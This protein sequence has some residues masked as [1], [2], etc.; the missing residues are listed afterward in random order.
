MAFISYLWT[1]CLNMCG[2]KRLLPL[3]LAVL[4][5]Y[6]LS[7]QSYSVS[8]VVTDKNSGEPVEF[9]TVVLQA[10]EQWAVADEKGRFTIAN[11]HPGKTV[12]STSC[13]GYVTDEME[14]V[15]SKSITNLNIKLA[16][17][18]LALEEAVVTAK[19]NSNSATTSRTI[20]KTALEHVQMMNVSDISNFREAFRYPRSLGRER[21]LVVR[22]SR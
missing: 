17:D 22:N 12:I 8:G 20:D 21:Q 3:L 14:I 5:P 2:Y 19:E 4:F 15:I 7:A 1:N 13:L 11:I 16:Q 6:V 18:N 10:T 9:A